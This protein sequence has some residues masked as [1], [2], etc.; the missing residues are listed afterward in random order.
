MIDGELLFLIAAVIT[1]AKLFWGLGKSSGREQMHRAEEFYRKA[2]HEP[3]DKKRVDLILEANDLAAPRDP[4][5]R[6]FKKLKR[7]EP[8]VERGDH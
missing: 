3:D 1:T 2:E 7:A 5:N 4:F 6:A 8:S